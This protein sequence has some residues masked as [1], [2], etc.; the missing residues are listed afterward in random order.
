MVKVIT[1]NYK[2]EHYEQ[3]KSPSRAEVVLGVHVFMPFSRCELFVMR[4]RHLVGF[5][6]NLPVLIL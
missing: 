5:A 2:D 4:G 1:G 3:Q 6:L